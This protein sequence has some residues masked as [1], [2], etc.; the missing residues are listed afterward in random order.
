MLHIRG[1]SLVTGERG[2]YKTR[3]GGGAQ[4]CLAM[5]KEE[6]GGTKSLR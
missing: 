5:L 3:Q 1:R 4:K 6:G 2:D